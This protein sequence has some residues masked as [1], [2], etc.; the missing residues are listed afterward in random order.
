M[1]SLCPAEFSSNPNYK[2]LNQLI[3]VLPG[4]LETPRQGR[5]KRFLDIPELVRQ[6][7]R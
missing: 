2:H 7:Y 5:A 3:K 4:I 6:E 1:E